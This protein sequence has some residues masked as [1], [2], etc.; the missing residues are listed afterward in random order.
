MA[1]QYQKDYELLELNSFSDWHQA[2]DNYRRLVHVWHPDK[3][4]DRPEESP[5]AQNQFIELSRAFNNLRSFYRKNHR[6]PFQKITQLVTDSAEPLAHQ[7]VQPIEDLTL[8]SGIL[9]KRK[10]SY[11]KGAFRPV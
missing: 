11:K 7:R 1:I 10:P 9:N 6:L 3:Y 2:R 5:H 4:I 8:A